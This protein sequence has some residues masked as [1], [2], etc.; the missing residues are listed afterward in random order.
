MS[1][2]LESLTDITASVK[3]VSEKGIP[4]RVVIDPMSIFLIALFLGILLIVASAGSAQV[5]KW[6]K[7]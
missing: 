6:I 5:E 3:N 4:V 1:N 2:P 7:T